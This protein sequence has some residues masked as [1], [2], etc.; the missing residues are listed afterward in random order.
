MVAFRWV[1]SFLPDFLEQNDLSSHNVPQ[2]LNLIT[3][4]SAL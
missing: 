2:K 3:L 1:T 4:F